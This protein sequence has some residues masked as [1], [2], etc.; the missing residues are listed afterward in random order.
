MQTPLSLDIKPLFTS[1]RLDSDFQDDPL[2]LK[3]NMEPDLAIHE[4]DARGAAEVSSPP[5]DEESGPED[6]GANKAIVAYLLAEV[7]EFQ[8]LNR[9]RLKVSL[10]VGQPGA[11]CR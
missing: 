2:L 6:Q 9:L 3:L 10:C 4:A 1:T 5:T 7:E 11:L 8:E